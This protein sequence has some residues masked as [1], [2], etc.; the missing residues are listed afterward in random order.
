MLMLKTLSSW[1]NHAHFIKLIFLLRA[2]MD[3]AEDGGM[4]PLGIKCVMG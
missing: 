4:C 2:V 3:I 1:L